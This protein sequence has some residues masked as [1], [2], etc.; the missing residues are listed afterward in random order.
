MH[1]IIKKQKKYIKNIIF[2]LNYS[3]NHCL[4]LSFIIIKRDKR[5]EKIF[6]TYI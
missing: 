5:R 6:K 3:V 4:V 1:Q 2:Y